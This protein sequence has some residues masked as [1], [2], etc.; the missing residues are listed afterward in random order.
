MQ[1]K[2]NIIP[3]AILAREI[4]ILITIF[5]RLQASFHSF[6]YIQ[7]NFPHLLNLS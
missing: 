6:N 7:G 2:I 4:L 5:R 1:R 3:A